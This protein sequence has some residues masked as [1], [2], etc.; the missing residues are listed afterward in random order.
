MTI[1]EKRMPLLAEFPVLVTAEND[2]TLLHALTI[3][4]GE[5]VSR[6]DVINFDQNKL[7]MQSRRRK[8]AIF[9][10]APIKVVTKILTV[11]ARIS[12]IDIILYR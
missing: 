11:L 10:D 7:P 8:P 1:V 3:T 12:F 2:I 5:T 6:K 4:R 9:C